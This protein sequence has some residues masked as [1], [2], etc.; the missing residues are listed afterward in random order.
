M[1]RDEYFMSIA[2]DNAKK[3]FEMGEIPIGAVAVQDNQI[4]AFAHNETEQSK[5]AAAHAELLCLQKAAEVIGDWR[6]LD[7]TLYS[8]LEPCSMCLGA[9][10][11]YRIK[12]LVWAAPD[13]R[14]GAC[15]S[16][17]NLQ[18]LPHPTH[19]LE[20]RKGVLE[21]ESAELMRTFFKRRR[22]AKIAR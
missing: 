4:I 7:V 2:L 14:H 13:L 22:D 16:F 17:C 3:A 1:N 10:F 19:N 12:T 6:C 9:M 21:T 5:Q 11:L 18:K 20:M 8:T 15:G